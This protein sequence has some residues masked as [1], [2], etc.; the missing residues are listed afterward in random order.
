MPVDA[1]LADRLLQAIQARNKQ[2]WVDTMIDGLTGLFF[3]A[4]TAG[5]VYVVARFLI[6]FFFHGMIDTATVALWVTAITLVVSFVSAWRNVNP[7]AGLVQM[8][9]GDHLMF[10]LGHAVSGYTHFNRHSVAGFALLLMGGPT[11]L[12]SALGNWLHRLPANPA[13][14]DKAV[15]ILSKYRPEVDL[16]KLA[17]SPKAAHL[18]RRLNLIV[19]R[20]ESTVVSLSTKGKQFV[21]ATPAGLD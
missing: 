6:L 21:G 7:F 20:D 9:A 15:E 10:S 18:L 12:L 11:N 16:G 17:D 14:I 1:R 19:V 13:V 2:L 4:L 3:T 8:S 5:V